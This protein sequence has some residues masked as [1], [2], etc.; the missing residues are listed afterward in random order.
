[1]G[2][3]PCRL[4]PRLV[5]SKARRWP[6]AALSGQ[7]SRARSRSWSIGAF[8]GHEVSGAEP[9]AKSWTP[10]G[11]REGVRMYDRETVELALMALGEGMTHAEAAEL[12]GRRVAGI[13]M[14][15]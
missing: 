2:V 14:P 12:C 15:C 13:K 8:P 5:F 11:V 7:W 1:M 9:R 3:D 10:G 4:S 6:I